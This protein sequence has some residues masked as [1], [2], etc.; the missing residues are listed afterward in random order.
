M[1]DRFIVLGAGKMG[2]VA[3]R[4][5]LETPEQTV[6]LADVREEALLAATEEIAE[7]MGREALHRLQTR[8]LDASDETAIVS[9]LEAHNVVL[10]A[11]YFTFN[12]KVAH[13]A[14]EAG[15]HYT[16]LGGHIMG[17]TERVLALS[18]VARAK[19]VTLIPD[20]GVAPGM[21]NVL[22]GHGARDLETIEAIE[23]YV[24]GIPQRPKPPFG[25]AHV[26][27]LEGLFDHYEDDSEI[28]RD[29]QRVRV[30]ALSEIETVYFPQ[31]GP[32]E[33][34]HTAG[35]T[36]TLI[37]TFQH[38]HNLMYKTVRYPGHA[39]RMQL[40]KTLGFFN[41]E[42]TVE[43]ESVQGAVRPRDVLLTMLKKELDLGDDDDVVLL[44]VQ[45]RGT[46]QGH[47]RERRYETVT[48][49]DRHK[50]VTAMAQT[51]AYSLAVVAEML[52]CGEIEKKGALPPELSVPGEMYMERMHARGV[53][54]HA[55]ERLID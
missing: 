27:S 4:A 18:E 26:F 9:A 1:G 14:V 31:F 23:I 25:Y 32:L 47:R 42:R 49:R 33:A 35:G 50:N 28:I 52:A 48:F 24:G 11:L 34:F 2:R 53:L 38:A 39:E 21:I 37:D 8:T 16:D 41:R 15:V 36:S 5:L 10:N 55:F 20:V 40:L 7:T 51:T 30:P 22:A 43:I 54:I 19:G 12:E 3:A 17:V 29:G 6:T 13:A 44:R 45:V 46:V